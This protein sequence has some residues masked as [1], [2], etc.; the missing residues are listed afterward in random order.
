[1]RGTSAPG[2]AVS[3]RERGAPRLDAEDFIDYF[4]VA[5]NTSMAFSPTDTTP[6]T[7]RAKLIAR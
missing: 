3:R 6:V 7:P 4:F 2:P 1:M 5:F